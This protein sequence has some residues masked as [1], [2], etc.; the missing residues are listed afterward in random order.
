M[1]VFS[2]VEREK[3]HYLT[4]ESAWPVAATT[5]RLESHGSRNEA[6]P[7]LL[8]ACCDALLPV[9]GV[10]EGLFRVSG[11]KVEVDALWNAA[12][13]C[14]NDV[15]CT[16][17]VESASCPA[18]LASLLKRW[19]SRSTIIADVEEQLLAV[20]IG[21]GTSRKIALDAQDVLKNL[22][23]VRLQ[24]LRCIF[25]LLEEVAV[26]EGS[27]RMNASA[28][29]TC[30]APCF[31]TTKTGDMEASEQ[32]ERAKRMGKILSI[33]VWRWRTSLGLA[34][35]SHSATSTSLEEGSG[36]WPDSAVVS[37]I[38]EN[39]DSVTTLIHTLRS[40]SD[41]SEITAAALDLA[42]AC[43]EVEGCDSLIGP[44][45]PC[46]LSSIT[47]FGTASVRR[48]CLIALSA[49]VKGSKQNQVAFIAAD[50][51][52]ILNACMQ[53]DEAEWACTILVSRSY[54]HDC[55]IDI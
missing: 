41:E 11:P 12:C 1:E 38:V 19:I 4:T 26:G 2:G 31:L 40:S 14:T 15:S 27:T 32:I 50:G 42:A 22:P 34:C 53:S 13:M 7:E 23:E 8:A 24:Q 55:H 37:P 10:E 28:L 30:M 5:G 54:C 39:M 52:S 46:L 16:E 36:W 17:V 35:S 45:I 6:P 18:T 25:A 48:N 29:G 51:L 43:V 47:Q 3:V 9:A 49:A 20:S 33:L 44:A 21:A